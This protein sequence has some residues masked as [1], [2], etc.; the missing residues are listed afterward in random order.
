M[1]W[2]IHILAIV[3]GCFIHHIWKGHSND[4]TCNGAHWQCVQGNRSAA[5]MW[6]EDPLGFALSGHVLWHLYLWSGAAIS[7]V[8]RKVILILL[9]WDWIPIMFQWPQGGHGVRF[10]E[11]KENTSRPNLQ[12]T[13]KGIFGLERLVLYWWVDKAFQL[14]ASIWKVKPEWDMCHCR[15][16]THASLLTSLFALEICKVKHIISRKKI[17]GNVVLGYF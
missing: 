16:I 1:T 9:S 12:L 7:L 11:Q 4:H 15:V 14:V 13:S 17:T 10:Y 6:Y 3:S 2:G 8:E 5:L